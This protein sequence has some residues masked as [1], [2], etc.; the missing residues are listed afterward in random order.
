MEQLSSP[1]GGDRIVAMPQETS[2][3]QLADAIVVPEASFL[4]TY[5]IARYGKKSI[6][7]MPSE[8]QQALYRQ[9]VSGFDNTTRLN[10]PVKEPALSAFDEARREKP[11]Y[12]QLV[13]TIDPE[14]MTTQRIGAAESPSITRLDTTQPAPGRMQETL[15]LPEFSTDGSDIPAVA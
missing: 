14:S 7:G 2:A 8:V 9:S 13:A 12:I 1:D 5:L 11:S 4:K 6:K 10:W 15:E 3:E